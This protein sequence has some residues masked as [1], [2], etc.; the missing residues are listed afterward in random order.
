MRNLNDVLD[1]ILEIAPEFEP[2]FKS[3][4]ESVLYSAPEALPMW[5]REGG[6]ILSEIA[7]GHPRAQEIC[8][9]FTD[10]VNT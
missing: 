1:Q 4:K 3:L 10:K 9:I 5:W 8:D 6:D 7:D 2:E